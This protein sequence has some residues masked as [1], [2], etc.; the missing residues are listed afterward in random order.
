MPVKQSVPVLNETY[1]TK[2]LDSSSSSAPFFNHVK[3][4]RQKSTSSRAVF[5][6]HQG[7]IAHGVYDTRNPP[8]GTRA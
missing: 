3:K 8:V 6:R 2:E 4:P 7:H 1:G 5:K